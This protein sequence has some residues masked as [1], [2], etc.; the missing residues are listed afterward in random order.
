LKNRCFSYCASEQKGQTGRE[1]REDNSTI[2]KI[3][4]APKL[5]IVEQKY[6]P[7]GNVPTPGPST[8]ILFQVNTWQPYGGVLTFP[9]CYLKFPSAESIT[10]VFLFQNNS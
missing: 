9:H 3:G 6:S 7:K 8:V 5:T 2:E 10:G 4:E 1:R